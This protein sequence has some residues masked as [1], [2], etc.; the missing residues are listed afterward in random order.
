MFFNVYPCKMVD[1]ETYILVRI[2]FKQLIGKL[3]DMAR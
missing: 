3:E 2:V 1:I